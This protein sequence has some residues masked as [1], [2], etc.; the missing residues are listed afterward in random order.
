MGSFD[1]E[2]GEGPDR[3]RRGAPDRCG[4]G[5]EPEAGCGEKV[6][7]AEVLDDDDPGVQ[8]ARVRRTGR[9]AGVVDVPEVD[10]DEGDLRLDQRADRRRSD[11]RAWLLVRG[12]PPACI[13]VGSDE[14]S[15]PSET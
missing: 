7:A 11:E 9:I 6:E 5:A 10:P 4:D 3:E 12:R 14:H 2:L 13:P 8:E 1:V 15:G